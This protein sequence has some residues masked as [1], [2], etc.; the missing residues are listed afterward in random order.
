MSKTNSQKNKKIVG[1]GG[2]TGLSTLLRALRTKPVD[3]TAV[4]TVAD[5]GGSSGRLRKE[6]GIL[7]PGDFRNCLVAL[8]D[9]EPLLKELF[10]YRFESNSELNGHSF[11]NL[12]IM[13]MEKVTGSFDKAIK[14]SSKVLNVTGQLI[15][16]TFEQVNLV[17]K[18]KDGIIVEGE[19]EIT[20]SNSSIIDIKLNPNNV[21]PS[22]QA[23]KAIKDSDV[24][25]IGPGSL[26]T[27]IIPNLLVPEI[28]EE[29]NNTKNP[30][31]YVCNIATQLGETTNYDAISHL[32]SIKKFAPDL[33]ISSILVNSRIEELG[34]EFP[35]S[36]CVI[37]ENFNSS[38]IEVKYSDLMNMNFKGHHDPDKLSNAIFEIL[39]Y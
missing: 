19:S 16:S 22:S 31:I 32:K 2:G 14:E 25:I 11:G 6:Y 28:I 36:T 26:Y 4:I 35:T 1:I 38:D 37:H 9:A 29:I 17:A 21:T 33:K 7:P 10:Q 12:F 39:N 15:P 8:S 5:N 34:E 24:I 20:N 18:L 23:L 27:S 13:A 30:V 3:L